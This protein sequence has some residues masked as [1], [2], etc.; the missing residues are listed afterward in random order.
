MREATDTSGSDVFVAIANPVRRALL[1]ALVE[2]PVPVRDL[3]ADFSISRP[4]ISQHL[5]VLKVAD[6]VTEERAGREHRY[7]LN[8]GPLQEVRAWTAHYER[9]WQNRLAALREVLDGEP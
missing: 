7:Q 6:L 3:A 1:D 9:F 8:A 2:G 4:A 5:K